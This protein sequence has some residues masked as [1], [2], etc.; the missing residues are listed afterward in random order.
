MYSITRKVGFSD[1]ENK[2]NTNAIITTA[3]KDERDR[4]WE[5]L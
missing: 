1:K 2:G 5:I 3:K 4:I